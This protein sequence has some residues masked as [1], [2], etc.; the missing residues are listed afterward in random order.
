M[1]QANVLDKIHEDLELI[2]RDMAEIKEVIKLEPE[3]RDEVIKQLQEARERISKGQFV[4]N[5]DILKEFDL[6]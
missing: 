6:E 2:K 5:E 1:S 4:S 3:L